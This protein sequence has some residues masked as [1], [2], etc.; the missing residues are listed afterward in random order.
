MFRFNRGYFVLSIVIFVIEVIIALYMKDDFIRPYV[1]DILVV[2][3]IYSFVKT[4]LKAPVLA[5]AKGVLIFCF[6]VE[7]LQ[8]I[9]LIDILGLGHLKWARI[10]IGTSFS[11]RDFV[12]YIIG[13]IIILLGEQYIF[14]HDL[15]KI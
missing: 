8:L 11:W 6:M 12:C 14:K 5:V 13:F 15:K 7:F 9:K 1:G 10:I 2:I 4:F 3:L